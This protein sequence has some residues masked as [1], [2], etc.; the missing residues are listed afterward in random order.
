M[1]CNRQTNTPATSLHPKASEVP[2]TPL[3]IDKICNIKDTIYILYF[4]TITI[5]MILSFFLFL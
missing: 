5:N 3:K 1:G 4:I 2:M